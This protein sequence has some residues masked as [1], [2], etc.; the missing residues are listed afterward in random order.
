MDNERK[1]K[2]FSSQEDF[3]DE[4]LT[5]FKIDKVFAGNKYRVEEEFPKTK[6]NGASY[7]WHRMWK[8]L[9]IV[10]AIVL[11][12]ATGV[13]FYVKYQNDNVKVDVNTF[14]ALNLQSLLSEINDA[15][16]TYEK[17]EKTL[18]SLQSEWEGLKLDLE[19]NRDAELF[20]IDQLGLD[21]EK[22]VEKRKAEVE[23]AYQQSLES[24][25]EDYQRRIQAQEESLALAKEKLE[26]FQ[27]NN[28][29]AYRRAEES[30]SLQTSQALKEM[31]ENQLKNNYENELL[32]MQDK[33]SSIQESDMERQQQAV[34]EVTEKYKSQVGRLDPEITDKKTKKIVSN[35]KVS[36]KTENFLGTR[37]STQMNDDFSRDFKD[38]FQQLRNDYDS[39]QALGSTISRTLEVEHKKDLPLYSKAF[40]RLTLS[41]GNDFA[42]A[43]ITE[44]KGHIE[45]EEEL[46][47]QVEN[48]TEELKAK[49][50]T[51]DSFLASLCH[52]DGFVYSAEG[53]AK[54]ELYFP[55]ASENLTG[56]AAIV[57]N[58]LIISAGH[59]YREE[60]KYF[61]QADSLCVTDPGDLYSVHQA[62][63]GEALFENQ[64][65][66]TGDEVVL[67]FKLPP[68]V[69]EGPSEVED[70]LE[71]SVKS[72]LKDKPFF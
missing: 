6:K 21:D 58:N 46:Q 44:I 57:R 22:E 3:V 1:I 68:K 33:L 9:L 61:Y 38:A 20:T 34:T 42:Q 59:V 41:A 67:L 71:N 40:T 15:K 2:S 56:Q 51:F 26:S 49:T 5:S 54:A 32:Q 28:A 50:E 47:G 65:M 11:L 16:G 45:K 52:G 19:R 13:W 60:E 70:T 10:L 4:L 72:A 27:K 48:L 24:A 12:A 37:W 14:E 53:A 43:S 25:T 18:E 17:E 63:E 64:T 29:D 30:A 8:P 31:Q 7:F 55:P 69:E 23:E 36:A 39:I 66:R 35:I 62:S